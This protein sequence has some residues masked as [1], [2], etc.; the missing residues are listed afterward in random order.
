MECRHAVCELTGAVL[1]QHVFLQAG[2]EFDL[3]V[4]LRRS[5]AARLLRLL[6]QRQSMSLR[7]VDVD[8]VVDNY[9]VRD[10]KVLPL[11]PRPQRL[12]EVLARQM[13]AAGVV[14][15]PFARLSSIW[16][17]QEDALQLLVLLRRLAQPSIRHFCGSRG[18]RDDGVGD[19][20]RVGVELTLGAEQ[21][22]RDDAPD[23]RDGA[24]DACTYEARPMVR[25]PVAMRA[26]VYVLDEGRAFVGHGVAALL[27]ACVEQ[28]PRASSR[29]KHVLQ[30]WR[31]VVG[32]YKLRAARR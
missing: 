19:G 6:Q 17:V 20:R 23:E 27:I 14:F 11:L 31:G 5:S 28:H 25:V 26:D 15:A 3:P 30:C 16:R 13:R 12:A 24:E 10:T 4:V 21:D 7:V 22:D 29:E 18:G 8:I 2:F 1:V 9:A 32:G